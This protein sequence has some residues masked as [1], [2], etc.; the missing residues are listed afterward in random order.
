M[1]VTVGMDGVVSAD[2]EPEELAKFAK[3]MIGQKQEKPVA[4]S[5]D[6]RRRVVAAVFKHQQQL[7]VDDEVRVPKQFERKKKSV[8]P[9]H[10]NYNYECREWTKADIKRLTDFYM[11]PANHY[12]DGNMI[13]MK[14]TGFAKS[15]NRTKGSISWKIIHLGLNR[16]L[17]KGRTARGGWGKVKGKKSSAYFKHIPSMIRSRPVVPVPFDQQR[18]SLAKKQKSHPFQR[19]FPKLVSVQNQELAHS[20]LANMVR[21]GVKEMHSNEATALG[22]SDWLEF[23]QE[24]LIEANNICAYLRRPNKFSVIR[25]GFEQYLVYG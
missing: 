16:K 23:L 22:I 21:G 3:A 19:P 18:L 15:E 2:G 17:V 20:A 1:K 7:P 25:K 4:T 14:E 13:G 11:D 5:A 9:E 24:V 10:I 8:Y 12:S 6:S